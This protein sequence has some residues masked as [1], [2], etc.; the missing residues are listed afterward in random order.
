MANHIKNLKG[1]RFGF[2]TVLK[3][4][5]QKSSPKRKYWICKCDCGNIKSIRSDALKNKT[6]PTISCGCYL[7]KDYKKL[8]IIKIFLDNVLG[9]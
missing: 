9:V 5:E 7:K 6:K 3:L 4:D 8:I 1:Q 2:L